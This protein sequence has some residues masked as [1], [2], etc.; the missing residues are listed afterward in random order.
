[1]QSV[2]K[3]WAIFSRG[4]EGISYILHVNMLMFSSYTAYLQLHIHVHAEIRLC[5]LQ[6]VFEIHPV[7]NGSGKVKFTWQNSVGNYLAVT[8]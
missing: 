8:G 2:V 1:M 3:L 6:A 7:I 4:D 5:A